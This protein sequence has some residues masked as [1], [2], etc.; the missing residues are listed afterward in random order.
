M[1]TLGIKCSKD[2]LDWAVVQ[3]STR[4]G[5]TEIDD[6]KATAPAGDRGAQLVWLRREVLELLERHPAEQVALRVAESSG[7]S[8]SLERVEVEG[9]VQEAIGSLGLTCHRLYAATLRSKYSARNAA[10]LEAAYASEPLIA[11]KAKTRRD[12][13]VVALAVLPA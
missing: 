1:L 7:Q 11:A 9:V 12:P 2:T 3:G 4:S 13:L 6:G 10:A 8:L 5:A